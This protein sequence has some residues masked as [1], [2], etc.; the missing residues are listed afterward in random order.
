MIFDYGMPA[1]AQGVSSKGALQLQLTAHKRAW[2]DIAR[3]T[4]LGQ[5]YGRALGGAVFEW[6]DQWWRQDW[7]SH[8]AALRHDDEPRG[9]GSAADGADYPEWYGL[10]SVPDFSDDGI[11]LRA[12]RPAYFYYSKMWKK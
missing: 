10:V 3:Q 12:P 4:A 7:R 5:G 8:K 2:A 9:A 11:F 6:S 1:L